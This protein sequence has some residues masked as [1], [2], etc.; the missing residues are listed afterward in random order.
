MAPK[1]KTS[2]WQELAT[3]EFSI[4]ILIWINCP[5]QIFYFNF[6]GT[7]CPTLKTTNFRYWSEIK[8]I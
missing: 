1:E 7:C 8:K 2:T 3:A 6:K 5:S 4:Y